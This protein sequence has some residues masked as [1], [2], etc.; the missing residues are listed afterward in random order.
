MA[1]W[2]WDKGFFNEFVR[3]NTIMP[4]KKMAAAG[5]LDMLKWM[6]EN[7]LPWDPRAVCDAAARA[8]HCFV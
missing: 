2:L 8:A 1:Q 5:H 6:R 7:K 3:A 4:C